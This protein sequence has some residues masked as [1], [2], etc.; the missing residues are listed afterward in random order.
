MD[1][2]EAIVKP[3]LSKP[4]AL[5]IDQSDLDDGLLLEITVSKED[6]G[7]LIGKQGANIS[8]IRELVGVYGMQHNLRFSIKINEPI[9]GKYRIN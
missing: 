7:H 2:L 1:Y 8:R 5:V 4:E 6:M 9:G 3:L